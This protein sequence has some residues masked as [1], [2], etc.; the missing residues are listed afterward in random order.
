MSIYYIIF[1]CATVSTCDLNN[2]DLDK[3]KD[4]KIYDFKGNMIWSSDNDYN[5]HDINECDK[6][7]NV[8]DIVKILPFPW[9]P[10]SPIWVQTF[11]VVLMLPTTNLAERQDDGKETEYIVEYIRD[12]YLDHLHVKAQALQKYTENIPENMYFFEYFVKSLQRH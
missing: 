5:I 4:V 12:G 3:D 10:F 7:Y 9:N 2:E 1:L 11:G 8:G 6:N